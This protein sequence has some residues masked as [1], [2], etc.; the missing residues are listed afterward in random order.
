[1]SFLL[2]C[3]NCGLREV[4]EFGFGG[5][6]RPRPPSAPAAH[7]LNAYLYFRRNAAGPQI[8][9]WHHR[10]GCRSWFL[11]ERDTRTNDVSWT[12]L[13]EQRAGAQTEDEAGT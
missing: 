11:A 3:P 8:E 9:W 1:M 12:H 2:E 5:E 4:T 13:P 6:V 7:D 10:S